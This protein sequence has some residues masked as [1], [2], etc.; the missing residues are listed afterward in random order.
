[1]CDGQNQREWLGERVERGIA[2]VGGAGE[3][4]DG[5]VGEWAGG[6]DVE[7]GG[8]REAGETRR[9][10]KRDGAPQQERKTE[11]G[12]VQDCDG[13][14]WETTD[15]AGNWSEAMRAHDGATD[16]AQDRGRA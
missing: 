9:A 14:G 2:Q 11:G 4:D 8:M 15:T 7:R 16:N 5:R 12:R 3:F 13:R 1:M 10:G 6:W